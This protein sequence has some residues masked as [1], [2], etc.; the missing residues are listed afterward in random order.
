MVVYSST[1]GNHITTLREVFTRLAKALLMVNLANSEFGK[2]VVTYPGKQVGQGQVRPINTKVEAVMD[3]PILNTKRELLRFLGMIGYYRA[4]CKNFST[5]VSPLTD[6]L[7][8]AREFRWNSK[9]DCAFG[10]AKDLLCSAPILSAPDFSYLFTLEVDA[11][12][13]GCGAVLTQE[14]ELGVHHPICYFSK[15]FSK[16]Q[17]RYST[18]EKEALALILALQHFEVYVGGSPEPV[19]VYTDHNPLVFLMRMCNS[20]QRLMRWALV[21]QGFNLKIRHK[22]G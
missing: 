14:G 15:N 6:L 12:V 4:F 17:R 8:T 2:A 16:A 18:I 7:S 9:C 19:A 5:I 1:W 13:V 3:F 22:K 21:I 10:A 11:S 20:N